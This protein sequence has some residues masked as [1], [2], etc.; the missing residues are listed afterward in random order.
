MLFCFAVRQYGSDSGGTV[1]F[2]C[3]T[4]GSV[5]TGASAFYQ[6]ADGF[7]SGNCDWHGAGRCSTFRGKTKGSF[8]RNTDRFVS[9]E[10][11]AEGALIACPVMTS[12]YIGLQQSTALAATM[13]FATLTL[14]RLFH[15]FNCRSQKSMARVGLGSNKYSMGAFL[16]GCILLGLVLCV[17]VLRGCLMW[18][19]WEC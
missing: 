10:I 17:P 19:K 7:A 1:Y 13:A 6:F 8:C 18:R 15:G 9:G 12:Y 11:V 5:C 2:T 14:A 4:S 16:G 3:R